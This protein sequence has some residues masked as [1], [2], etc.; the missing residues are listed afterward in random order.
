MLADRVTGRRALVTGV[1]GQD[2]SYLAELLASEGYEVVG[3]VRPGRAAPAGLDG[4]V[5]ADLVDHDALVGAVAEARPHELYHLAAPTFVP[6]SWDDPSEVVA[7]VAGAT[8]ALLAAARRTGPAMRVYVATSS[9]IFGDS[10]ESPQSERSPMRPRT[11]Y[12][13][14]KLA[15]HG[16][17][18]T[19]RE[20]HGLFA[21]SGITYNHESP[22]RPAHFLPRKVTSGAVRIALGL[23]ETLALGDLDAVRDWSHAA[24]IV[25]GAWLALR[26]GEPRDYVLASGVGRTV[27]DLVEAAFAA[28]GISPEGRVTVDPAFV[29]PPEPTPLVGDPS[30]ARRELGWEPEH[31]FE[32][33]IA[34][35]VRA[36]LDALR[37]GRA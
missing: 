33:T 19:F 20:R 36:D 11:P 28:A 24:D 35:M 9:E 8:A 3:M 18:R 6:A 37:E 26:A 1:T 25:R 27:R 12:G 30:L 17:V 23:E 34:E 31:S 13:V 29:R 16:L 10:G 4:V 7:A 2:G 32:E 15:A 21:V 5:E 22:R 14:A